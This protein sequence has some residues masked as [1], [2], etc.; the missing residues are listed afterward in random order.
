[1]TSL[2]LT[3]ENIDRIAQAVLR[4]HIETG[5]IAVAVKE[6]LEREARPLPIIQ[7]A[8]PRD[9]VYHAFAVYPKQPPAPQIEDAV[10]WYRAETG[11]QHV[12][13]HSRAE[14]PVPAGTTLVIDHRVPV[15]VVFLE[16]P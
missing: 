15:N 6:V 16:M 3:P 14:V 4:E 2:E 10:A 13:I 1:M 12:P 11:R 8:P 5:F 7:P 9:I